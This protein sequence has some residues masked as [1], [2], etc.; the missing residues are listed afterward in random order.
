MIELNN[1]LELYEE[2]AVITGVSSATIFS[3][4]SKSDDRFD[5]E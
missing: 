4:F 1:T 2:A 3:A 5:F